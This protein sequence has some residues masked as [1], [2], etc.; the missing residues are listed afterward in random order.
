MILFNEVIQML[1]H[2]FRAEGRPLM[3]RIF[4][5]SNYNKVGGVIF[6]IDTT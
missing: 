5:S 3:K 2:G 6:Q 1:T 4:T